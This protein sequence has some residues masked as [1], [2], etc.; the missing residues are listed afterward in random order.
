MTPAYEHL[1]S[2]LTMTEKALDRPSSPYTGTAQDSSWNTTYKCDCCDKFH[3][4]SDLVDKVLCA[5]GIEKLAFADITEIRLKNLLTDSR[6]IQR[7]LNALSKDFTRKMSSSDILVLLMEI[8][9]Y[10]CRAIGR[11]EY[12]PQK[13][14]KCP[15]CESP[16]ED[17][18][19]CSDVGANG[20][21][22]VQEVPA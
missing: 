17:N 9:N 19:S 12:V 11:A 14:S 13:E 21:G 4:E 8:A 10:A 6:E 16:L 22:F 7:Q 1:N 20:C 15:E 3:S 18:G 5:T 2:V